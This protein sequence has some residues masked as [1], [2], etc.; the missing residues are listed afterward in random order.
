MGCLN[1]GFS[2]IGIGSGFSVLW[3]FIGVFVD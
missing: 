1:C 2:E 3:D